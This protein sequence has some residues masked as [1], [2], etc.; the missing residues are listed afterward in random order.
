MIHHEPPQ[1]AFIQAR[2]GEII[3]HPVR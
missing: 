1:A 2:K 3:C